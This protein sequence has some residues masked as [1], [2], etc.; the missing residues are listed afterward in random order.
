MTSGDNPFDFSQYNGNQVQQPSVGAPD[1]GASSTFTSTAASSF[2]FGESFQASGSVPP[3]QAAIGVPTK[4]LVLA[5]AC[6]VVSIGVVIVLGGAPIAAITA[7]L[8][9]GPIAI[10]LLAVFSIRDT[11]ARTYPL[12]S[13]GE[14]VPWIYRLGFVLSA[15]AIVISAMRIANWMGRL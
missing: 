15:V 13:S 2:G 4:W 10:V 9:G 14:L 6:A 11:Q 3:A 1:R 8:L 12:Y 7:W 5:I